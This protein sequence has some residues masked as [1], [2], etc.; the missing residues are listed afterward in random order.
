M[1]TLRIY[2]SGQWQDSASPCPWALCDD[3]GIVL[4]SGI[5]PLSTLP[6]GRDCIAIIAPDRVLCVAAKLPA[7]SRRRWQV[8]LSFVAEEHT[9]PD[10]EDNHV[11]PGPTL[12]D[13]RLMLAVVDK[14][15]TRR[16]VE[17]CRAQKLTLR[18]MVPETFLPELPVA[19]WVLVWD[20]NNG[21]VRTGPASGI[22]LDSGSADQAPLALRLLLNGLPESMPDKILVRPASPSASPSGQT[23]LT[24][25]PVPPLPQWT[26]LPVP[27]VAGPPWDWQRAPVAENSLNLLWGDF[28]SRTPFREWWP[29]VRPAVW[30]LLAILAVEIIGTNLQW[31]WLSTEKNHLTREMER[32]F[33]TT[34]GATSTLVNAPLQMQRN[35]SEL[36][37]NA[38]LPDDSD[39]LPLLN[40]AAARLAELPLGSVRALH[41]EAG[42]LDVELKLVNSAAFRTLQQHLQRKGLNVNLGEIQDTGRGAEA[43]MSLSPGGVR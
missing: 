9:L 28:A 36:R 3:S 41:Y 15:W 32:T 39:F 18:A 23:S 25:T 19:T 37:H 24:K 21:F 20:G 12:A 27:L 16:I 17:A 2:F 43:R 11:V 30:V 8:A 31:V 26:D 34:F 22:T 13:G 14:A 33:R 10:P 7:G 6:H 35:L 4:Q 5:G 42:R 40:L 38:G 1:T 29:A